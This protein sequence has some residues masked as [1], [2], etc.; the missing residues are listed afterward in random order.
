MA[1]GWKVTKFIVPEQHLLLPS[2]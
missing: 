2:G 1:I